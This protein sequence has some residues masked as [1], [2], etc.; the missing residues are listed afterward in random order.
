M[1]G[2][3]DIKDPIHAE[4]TGTVPSLELDSLTLS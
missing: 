4:I 3:N 2:I 1:V